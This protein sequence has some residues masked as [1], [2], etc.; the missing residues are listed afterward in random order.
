MIRFT[1]MDMSP[2]PMGYRGPIQACASNGDIL[3]QTFAPELDDGT[4][5]HWDIKSG[6]AKCP[7]DMESLVLYSD[8]SK[9]EDWDI[10]V[11]EFMDD[12]TRTTLQRMMVTAYVAMEAAEDALMGVTL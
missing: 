10:V 5:L 2:V 6:L 1:C 9:Y 3:A 12:R 11:N 8:P 4:E 7:K